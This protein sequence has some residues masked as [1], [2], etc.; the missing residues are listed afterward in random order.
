MDIFQAPV[1]GSLLGKQQGWEN[2]GRSLQG[3]IQPIVLP[4]ISPN[5]YSRYEEALPKTTSAPFDEWLAQLEKPEGYCI[6]HRLLNAYYDHTSGSFSGRSEAYG[7]IFPYLNRADISFAR[8]D[9]RRI[10]R[11][12]DDVYLHKHV[13]VECLALAECLTRWV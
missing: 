11:T 4:Q 2:T 7:K 1:L 10:D 8:I 13:Q 9:W 6:A 3:R 12:F 5:S